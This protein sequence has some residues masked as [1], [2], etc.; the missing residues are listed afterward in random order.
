MAQPTA[1]VRLPRR[2]FLRSATAGAACSL[3]SPTAAPLFGKEP[4]HG[5]ITANVRDLGLQFKQNDVDIAGQDGATSALLPNGDALWMFGDTIEGPFETI[6]NHP[7]EGVLSNTASIVPRQ[8]ASAGLKAY[9][10]LKDADGARARQVIAFEE[11]EDPALHRLWP[12]HSV[13]L[14]DDVYTYYIKITMDPDLD[15][16]DSLELNGNGIAKAK[17]GEWRFERLRNR[18]GE[19]TFWGGDQPTYGVFSELGADGWLYVWG[20]FWTGM[21]LARVKPERIAEPDA[22]QYLVEAPTA[23]KPNVVPRWGGAYN[24]RAALFDSV[25][26]E[27]SVS[28]NPYLGKYLAMHVWERQNK[29]VFRTAPKI[30]GPW[31]EPEVF[32]EPERLGDDDLFTAGKEHPELRREN[33]K[34][35]YVTYVNSAVY[36]P[37]LIEV[38]LR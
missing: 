34:V 3:A 27:L 30:T 5:R 2:E 6:R 11:D 10:Y 17:V 29:L 26:N 35:L 18:S 14:G 31:S 23:S 12:M 19:R 33:G 22:Y 32:F 37:H 25:P 1:S 16:F 8:D 13:V 28:Y 20:S 38:T 36:M 15:V 24:P 21:Y 4:A 7:L 9:E